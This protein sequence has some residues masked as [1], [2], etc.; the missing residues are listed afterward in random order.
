MVG[1]ADVLAAESEI[2]HRQADA[3]Y[4]RGL[5]DRALRR[6]AAAERHEDSGRPLQKAKALEVA[7][8]PFI[9]AD[10]RG[11]GRPGLNG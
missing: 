8:G 4:R 11:H 3:L 6:L 7:A 9:D 1:Q 5:L 2:A 10:E